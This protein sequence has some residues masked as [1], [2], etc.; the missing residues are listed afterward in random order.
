MKKA[1]VV[2]IP[3]EKGV[4]AVEI[5]GRSGA[6]TAPGA[7]KGT[8]TGARGD[9]KAAAMKKMAA[10]ARKMQKADPAKCARTV[11]IRDEVAEW[12]EKTTNDAGVSEKSAAEGEKGAEVRKSRRKDAGSAT[13][14]SRPKKAAGTGTTHTRTGSAKRAKAKQPNEKLT[15]ASIYRKMIS[16]GKTYQ[17]DTEQDFIEAARI[18]AEEAALI[19]Q[20]RDRIAEDGLTVEKTYKTGSVE[21]AH[22][23][24]SEL[25]RHV[26]SAN[27]CL[28]TIGN[29]VT[30]RGAKKEKAARDLDAFR[31]H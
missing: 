9:G 3:A 16:F 6:K 31:L 29:M 23:L 21:V 10:G 4:P 26:E 27:K 20:M 25:P 7:G 19:A 14:T 28:A 22:P 11:I 1:E 5:R 18:Y 24:L 13:G 2:T 17:V 15:P 8:K 12:A 30:E